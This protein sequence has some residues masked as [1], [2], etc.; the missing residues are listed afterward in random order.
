TV[1][2]EGQVVAIAETVFSEAGHV[3]ELID[4]SSVRAGTAEWR[5]IGDDGVGRPHHRLVTSEDRERR[6]S[7]RKFDGIIERLEPGQAVAGADFDLA[8]A[9]LKRVRQEHVRTCQID[10]HDLTRGA[11]RQASLTASVLASLPSA[12]NTLATMPLAS[13]PARAYIA[14]GVS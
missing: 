13:R 14:F 2:I 10:F 12:S 1:D 7:R 11:R 9:D 5:E 4:C 6:I 3:A 8:P